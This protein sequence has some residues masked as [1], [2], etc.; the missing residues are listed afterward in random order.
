MTILER[1]ED[2]RVVKFDL[3]K[4]KS[5]CEAIEMCD[6]EFRIKLT[7]AEVFQLANELVTLSLKMKK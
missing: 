5:E 1:L 7:K 6:E 2:E 4:D 3:N